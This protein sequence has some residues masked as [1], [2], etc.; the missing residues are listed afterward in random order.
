VIVS[1]SDGVRGVF[2]G[3]GRAQRVDVAGATGDR[4]RRPGSTPRVRGLEMRRRPWRRRRF[5]SGVDVGRRRRMRGRHAGAAACTAAG[6]TRGGGGRWPGRER[7]ACWAFC[8]AA[9]ASMPTVC[10]RSATI[11][12]SASMCSATSSFASRWS[13]RLLEQR[14]RSRCGGLRAGRRS[15][16][17]ARTC[18]RW[19]ACAWLRRLGQL[20]AVLG[21][22]LAQQRRRAGCVG[23]AL[24]AQLG[25][26]LGEDFAQELRRA[27]GVGLALGAQLLPVLAQ[28]DR[29]AARCSAWTCSRRWASSCARASSSAAMDA[30]L[31]SW[32]TGSGCGPWRGARWRP[33]A[34]PRGAGSGAGGP[35]KDQAE[36]WRWRRR[37]ELQRRGWTRAGVSAVARAVHGRGLGG[38]PCGGGAGGGL[39]AVV[40]PGGRGAEEAHVP[41]SGTTRPPT[42]TNACGSSE[43]VACSS[44]R[45]SRWATRR[46]GR[47]GRACASGAGARPPARVHDDA[48]A[49]SG[50]RTG[51]RAGER[52]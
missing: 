15:G 9:T 49:G 21:R 14:A 46:P 24:G 50:R 27:G 23:L 42:A 25:A 6:S 34:P 40:G 47:L 20:G 35:A 41:K 1:A 13:V 28:S 22:R 4:T 45:S 39:G 48:P 5:A 36:P 11:E 2:G 30:A 19:S 33:G 17:W 16:R 43:A 18:A 3:R 8:V 12:V 31:A 52:S 26:V 29:Q 32:A 37:R 10:P 51:P 7:W 38:G 44:S